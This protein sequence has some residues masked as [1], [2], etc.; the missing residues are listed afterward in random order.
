MKTKVLKGKTLYQWLAFLHILG[1]LG[2]LLSHGASASVTFAL[3]QERNHERVSALLTLST[4]SYPVMYL[5]LL[6]LLVTGIITGVMGDWWGRGWIWTSLVLLIAIIVAMSLLGANKLSDL[7]KAIGLPYAVRGKTQPAVAPA[8][9]QEIDAL[10]S[11]GNPMLL[12]IIGFGG[13]AVVAWLM[14]FKPF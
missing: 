13:I 2:F 7:R 6:I 10:L 1:V 9:A 8:S 3:R 11:Q 5:S 14:M 4:S 12:T